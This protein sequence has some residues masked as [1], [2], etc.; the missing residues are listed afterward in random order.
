[1]SGNISEI[2]NWGSRNTWD[3]MEICIKH[4]GCGE[5]CS[6]G[7]EHWLFWTRCGRFRVF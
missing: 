3:H 5:L 6:T 1:M 2:Q 7:T 4:A